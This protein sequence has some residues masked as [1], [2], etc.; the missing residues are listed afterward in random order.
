MQRVLSSLTR[1]RD[2]ASLELA[3]IDTELAEKSSRPDANHNAVISL[4]TRGREALLQELKDIEAA[5]ETFKSGEEAASAAPFKSGREMENAIETI[6][7]NYIRSI[8]SP[9]R[10]AKSTLHYA[11]RDILR[12]YTDGVTPLQITTIVK[13]MIAGGLKMGTKRRDPIPKDLRRQTNCNRPLYKY[14]EENDGVS[15][16]SDEERIEKGFPAKRR[17]RR[18]RRASRLATPTTL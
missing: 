10:F 4:L 3:Q 14:Y 9:G 12:D 18:E 2:A 6:R 15:L 17:K 5:I 8:I 7:D 11:T 13:M 1:E 16:R